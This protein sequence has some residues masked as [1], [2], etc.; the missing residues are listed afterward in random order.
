MQRLNIKQNYVVNRHKLFKRKNS[1]NQLTKRAA[2]STQ[3]VRKEQAKIQEAKPVVTKNKNVQIVEA[4]PTSDN[5]VKAV[6][7]A[8]EKTPLSTGATKTL[9]VPQ[10]VSLDA[11]IP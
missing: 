4:K 5:A 8:E 11:S 9:T 1:L 6:G 2:P 3:T 7:P 10:G